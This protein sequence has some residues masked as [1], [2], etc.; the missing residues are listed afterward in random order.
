[1]DALLDIVLAD[2]DT[3][4]L[5]PIV[6]RHALKGDKTK[7]GRDYR[8]PLRRLAEEGGKDG[9]LRMI[10]ELHLPSYNRLYRF[11]RPEEADSEAGETPI[12]ASAC[13]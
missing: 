10:F 11:R 4:F 9:K 5:M 2:T 12:P 7:D 13:D 3:S 6:K 8:A 1:M